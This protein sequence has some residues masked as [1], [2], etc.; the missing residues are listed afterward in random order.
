MLNLNDF[1][2][3]EITPKKMDGVTLDI[4]DPSADLGWSEQ[5]ENYW[6]YQDNQAFPIIFDGSRS[7]RSD[8]QKSQIPSGNVMCYAQGRLAVALPDRTTFRIGD[9]VFGESGTILN[10]H[11]DAPLYF[12]E[13]NYLNEG[14]DFA[15]R[16]FGAPSN[17]GVIK[18]MIALAQTDT[19]LGQGSVLVGCSKMIFSL[20]LPFDRTTWKN[21]ANALQTANPINGPLG[22]DSTININAD[23]WFRRLDG[24]G[25]FML[26]RRE[27]QSSWTNTPMSAEIQD[28]LDFDTEALL[29][30]GSAVYWQNRMLMTHSP[31]N[32]PIGVWHRGLVA[33]DFNLVSTIRG[34]ATPAWE[35]IWE[36]L[37][38]LKIVTAIVGNVE[39]CYIYALSPNDQV[40]VWELDNDANW[41]DG[42][43]ATTP[44]F[45]NRTIDLRSMTCGDSDN[46]KRL[47]TARLVISNMVG[48]AVG[49]L[50]YRT[51]ESP[52][53]NPWDDFNRCSKYQDCGP[54][55]CSGPHTFR[56][57]ERQPIRFKMPPDTFSIV[58]GLKNR[59]G[60]EFQPR[61]ELTGSFDVR[62]FRIF[63]LDQAEAIGITERVPK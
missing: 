54:P 38:I 14:G 60:Y 25:S 31:V 42:I 43:N 50:K 21:L 6:V 3:Q 40:E 7:V 34:K 10:G 57:Q 13:N 45:I 58:S 12:T 15:A 49:T 8:P 2:V 27:F 48:P 24:I 36:G 39:R 59:T 4:N 1:S 28:I 9:I 32:D 29:E 5:V 22:Q 53:W 52:C 46:F 35:G 61:L 17:V 33:L 11:R 47:E 37:R 26:A 51:D 44:G 62:E 41:D 63:A 16:V 19:Q 55:E 20:N 23:V 30:H 56:E 18:S